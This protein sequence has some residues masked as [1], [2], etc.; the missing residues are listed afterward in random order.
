MRGGRE[1]RGNKNNPKSSILNII[2]YNLG[3]LRVI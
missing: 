1:G 2:I 3:Y